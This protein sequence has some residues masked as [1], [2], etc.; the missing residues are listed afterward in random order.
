MNPDCV[1]PGKVYGNI[2]GYKKNLQD[3]LHVWL[4]PTTPKTSLRAMLVSLKKIVN[5]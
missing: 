5:L 4:T 3:N 2:Q 1:Q